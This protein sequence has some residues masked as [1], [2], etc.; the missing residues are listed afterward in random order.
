M[1]SKIYKLII[2][3][4]NILPFKKWIYQLLKSILNDTSKFSKD[5][6]FVGE[7]SIKWRNNN[8][9]FYNYGGSLENSIFWQGLDQYEKDEN[10]IW[11]LLA[12]KS[13]IIFDIGA[14][15]G[16]YSVMTKTINPNATVYAF[17][18]SRN[19]FEKLVKNVKINKIDV[20]CNQIAI[21][22]S[23]KET[24]CFDVPDEHQK[25]ASL[26]PEKL[27]NWTGYTGEIIEYKVVCSSLDKYIENNNITSIDL[28]KIDVE[29]H[30]AEVLKGFKK[31]LGQFKPFMMIE[32]LSED[33]A[34]A[35]DKILPS[36]DYI[37]LHL[38]GPK[39]SILLSNFLVDHENYNYLVFHNTRIKDIQH[40]IDDHKYLKDVLEN[41]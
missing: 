27:K 23:N 5:L 32:V 14:N 7:F 12:E 8:V 1:K 40:L 35:L 17:E 30:E 41:I 6:N 20:S 15:T 25:S 36:K 9:L 21:S 18:P 10:W 38:K 31:Y 2:T 33:I 16:I 19:T 24:I 3:V 13:K 26:S 28:M 29:M 22:N 37:K 4:L 11:N 34:S 39:H